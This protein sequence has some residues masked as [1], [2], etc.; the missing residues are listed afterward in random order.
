MVSVHSFLS[1]NKLI[2]KAFY[3][4]IFFAP[5]MHHTSTFSMINFFS[6]FVFAWIDKKS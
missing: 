4:G 3:P 6:Q 1:L 5:H 2:F